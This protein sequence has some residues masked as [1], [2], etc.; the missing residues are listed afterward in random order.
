MVSPME[1]FGEGLF[2][3]TANAADRQPATGSV[4]PVT[5]RGT[6]VLAESFH[7]DN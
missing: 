5:D 7:G 2:S 6:P 1:R 4:T 3:A